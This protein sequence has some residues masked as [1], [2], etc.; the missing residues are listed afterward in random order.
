MQKL[1]QVLGATY[2]HDPEEKLVFVLTAHSL[3]KWLLISDEPDKLYYSCDIDALVKEAFANNVWVSILLPSRHH[4][5]YCL[6]SQRALV[7]DM[8]LL[9]LLLVGTFFD[10]NSVG[11]TRTASPWPC[12]GCPPP[13]PSP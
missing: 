10:H 6:V 8:S 7:C 13:R 2:D 4:L 11:F 5:K 3:Q 9:S 12:A 1:V